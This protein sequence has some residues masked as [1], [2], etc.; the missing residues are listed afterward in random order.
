VQSGNS[1]ILTYLPQGWIFR[2]KL[3]FMETWP[4]WEFVNAFT[5]DWGKFYF[6]NLFPPFSLL[7]RCIRKI[8]T[9][10]AYKP[11]CVECIILLFRG[12]FSWWHENICWCFRKSSTFEIFPDTRH[13]S[14]VSFLP[15]I[16]QF[17]A[18]FENVIEFLS[19]LQ[20]KGLGYS[21]I[22]TVSI[23]NLLSG[24]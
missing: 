13:A 22:N 23:H 10:K 19:S 21:S 1:Q 5:V 12:M 2:L 8:K 18:S 24:G 20:E 15:S 4:Q 14:R 16:N 9:D 11:F 6:I 3:V 7:N 17:E